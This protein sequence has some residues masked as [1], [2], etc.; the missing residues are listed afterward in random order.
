MELYALVLLAMVLV[1]GVL[2]A[3]LAAPFSKDG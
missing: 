1:I 3:V 2:Y